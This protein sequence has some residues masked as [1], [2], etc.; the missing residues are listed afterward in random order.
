MHRLTL[1][2][3]LSL[4]ALS[5]ARSLDRAGDPS[6]EPDPHTG[7]VA[8]PSRGT[9]TAG[10]S[11]DPVIQSPFSIPANN[12]LSVSPNGGKGAN[13][14]VDRTI[15][16]I[17]NPDAVIARSGNRIA[18]CPALS[19]IRSP[20]AD[21]QRASLL[22]STRTHLDGGAAEQTV[23]ITTTVG[24][25][26]HRKWAGSTAFTTGDNVAFEDARN[27]V[28]RLASPA[29]TSA[30]SGS[31]PGGRGRGIVDGTCRWDWINDAAINAKVGLYN[32]VMNVAGGGNSW[33]QANNF[34]LRPGHA[35]LFH[36]NTELDFQND[37]GTDC[38]PGTSNCLGLYV[39][40]GGTNR[41][42]SGISVEGL[43]QGALFG[44]RFVGPLAANA[45]ISLGTTGGLTGIAIG[46][47]TPASYT[48]AAISD[49]S[50]APHG[51]DLAGTN[52]LATIRL[53]GTAAVG[54]D[55]RA[56]K[57]S[58]AQVLGKGWSVDGAGSVTSADLH[59]L[60]QIHEPS[61]LV[62]NRSTSP[63]TPGQRSWDADYEYRCVA[64]NRWKRAA[65]S[66][67]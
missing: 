59:V 22:V 48:A 66:S 12:A 15:A 51:L 50:T 60:G 52:A 5:P 23:G 18:F 28:Y 20:T 37:S 55:L 58:N 13:G 14:E 42:T 24:T 35:P 38:A 16:K 46:G 7:P 19:C 11:Q 49:S 3:V 17:P 61:P 9:I 67:W 40:M 54:I 25:G 27:A 31:G 44:A 33:A 8:M 47:F 45:T 62:P 6:H 39:R 63:C 32:E 41:S 30:S 29:C 21:H 57:L 1:V 26:F 2:P 43:G 53:A 10:A 56:A 34:H 65:L 4:V 36:A 64:T